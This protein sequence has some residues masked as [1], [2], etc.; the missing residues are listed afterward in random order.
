MLNV[1]EQI[2]VIKEICAYIWDVICMKGKLHALIKNVQAVLIIWIYGFIF[3][4]NQGMKKQNVNT[5]HDEVLEGSSANGM[6][7]N[8]IFF[9]PSV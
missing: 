9:H 5:N 2:G 7:S 4:S 6:L 8:N 1:M 3:V